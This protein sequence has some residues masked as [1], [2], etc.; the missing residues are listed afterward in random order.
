[1]ISKNKGLFITARSPPRYKFCCE[2]LNRQILVCLI[3]SV[4]TSRQMY[5]D[6]RCFF[7]QPPSLNHTTIGERRNVIALKRAKRYNELYLSF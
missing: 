4:S 6:D 2:V 3:L 5:G 1:M 7:N